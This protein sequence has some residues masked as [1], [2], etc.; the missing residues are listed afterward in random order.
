M[1]GPNFKFPPRNDPDASFQNDIPIWMTFYIS[2][3]S[4]FNSNRTKA[5]IKTKPRITIKIPYPKQFNT[6]N[7]QNYTAGGSL[8]VQSVETG[9]LIGTLYQEL[10]ATKELASSFF[11][12]GGVIR[13][14]HMETI[15][16]PGGRR[17]HSF[18]IN[19]FARTP[20]EAEEANSIALTFQANMYPIAG[21]DSLLTMYHPP[22]W[23]FEAM[24]ENTNIE[25]YHYYWD[26]N[27]LP[28]VL[29]SVDINR[30]AI[31]NTP[32]TTKDYKPLGV[33]IK[34]L[35]IELEPAM[36]RGYAGGQVG[37]ADLVS[38]AQRFRKE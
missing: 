18:D 15:L 4:T 20:A 32:F 22:L 30:S 24:S 6:S 16:D 19:L 28:S 37:G 7:T 9:S 33:N 8:N 5:Y 10:T 1:P 11:S 26:G 2:D 31:L 38:R 12:G 35:F 23:Y 34:L 13:F 3:Y 36:Q 17:S 27:A 25:S 21:T 29:K 14:D